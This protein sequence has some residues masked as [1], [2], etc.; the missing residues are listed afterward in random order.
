MFHQLFDSTRLFGGVPL[1][2]LMGDFRKTA[3]ISPDSCEN[4]SIYASIR[5]SHLW[6]HVKEVTLT[7]N[8]CQTDA[9]YMQQLQ[10]IGDGTYIYR[11]VPVMTGGQHPIL[12]LLRDTGTLSHQL[13]VVEQPTR[14]T[15]PKSNGKRFKY[16]SVHG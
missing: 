7:R 3:P 1:F 14:F 16:R 15:G 8:F 10:Q 11:S 4:R 12:S 6:S 5:M 2:V 9:Q 13:T